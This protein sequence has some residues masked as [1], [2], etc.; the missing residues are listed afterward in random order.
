MRR[1]FIAQNDAAG[2]LCLAFGFT[3]MSIVD[4]RADCWAA[5]VFLGCLSLLEI[6]RRLRSRGVAETRRADRVNV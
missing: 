6:N 5:F 2:A 1:L 3:L 4:Y